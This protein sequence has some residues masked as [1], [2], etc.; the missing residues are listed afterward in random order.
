LLVAD[1][2]ECV[3]RVESDS[4]RGPRSAS[5]RPG[6][7]GPGLG[8]AAYRTQGSYCSI[9]ARRL[10]AVEARAFV[11]TSDLWCYPDAV[12][13]DPG[14]P[15]AGEHFNVGAGLPVSAQRGRQ[16]QRGSLYAGLVGLGCRG[17]ARGQRVELN[18]GG[19]QVKQVQRCPRLGD[20]AQCRL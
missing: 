7:F 13:S 2:T 10:P 4:S 17:G 9:G 3:C 16:G 11:R 18:K 5:D 12:T 8:M 1:R 6:E 14:C 15:G 20:A 19:P